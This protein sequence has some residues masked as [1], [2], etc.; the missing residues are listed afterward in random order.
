MGH[1]G[2]VTGSPERGREAF[3]RRAWPEAY[4]HFAA[5]ADLD[6]EDLQ[7][8]AVAAHLVGDDEASARAW[9]A[10]HARRAADGDAAGAAYC[11]GWLGMQLMLQGDVAQA[12]GWFAR[13]ER[14]VEEHGVEGP[15]R[16]YLMIPTLLQA[17]MGGDVAVAGQLADQA[18]TIARRLDEPDLFGLAVLGQGQVALMLGEVDRAMRLF[19]EVMVAVTGEE[20]SPVT[21]GIVYCAVIEA[22]IA[23]WDLR[24]AAEWTEALSRWCAAQPGLVPYRGQCLVHRSQVLLARGSWTEAEREADRAREHLSR[25]PAVGLA[26][27]QRA[28]LHRLRGELD[29]AEEAYRAAHDHGLDPAPGLALLRLAQG[30]AA[31]ARSTI[32]RMLDE[33]RDA[34]GRAPMLT[35]AVEIDL[36]A[37]DV[38]GAEAAAAELEA[39]GA[40]VGAPLLRAMADYAQ[41]AV[42]LARGEAAPALERLRPAQHA[43]R[44]LEMPYEA[45]RAQLLIGRA[46]AL[47]DD[48]DTAELELAA[49]RATFEALGAR[50]DAEATRPA[51]RNGRRR[52][53]TELTE[54]EC[55]VLRLVAS[56]KTNRHIAGELFI[57]EHTVGRHLQ[58]IFRKLDLT[59]RAAAT[60]YAYEHDLI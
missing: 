52:A 51:A 35:T 36:A 32:R 8:L 40:Q 53:A 6:G 21:A 16:G 59:S 4:E 3:A 7:R 58:N 25:H 42:R 50:A 15:V 54:R 10:A 22:C 5:A 33:H 49:A 44:E 30:R 14:L 2:T 29:A 31:A 60:A 26:H 23:A 20:L 9:E 37:D 34:L 57:S 1:T 43:W 17:I 55:E 47:L 41:G 48:R 46:C 39:I 38:G 12:S 24:R 45:A 28:E 19:D 11:A 13:A 56:G 18:A 27:Y